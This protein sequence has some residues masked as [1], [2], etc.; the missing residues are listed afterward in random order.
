MDFNPNE[1]AHQLLTFDWYASKTAFTT[2]G[3]PIENLLSLHETAPSASTWKSEDL[4]M[5]SILDILM[6]L[7][8]NFTEY[9]QILTNDNLQQNA[10]GSV[11]VMRRNSPLSLRNVYMHIIIIKMCKFSS[12]TVANVL[13]R[14]I[15]FLYDNIG[16]LDIEL[17]HRIIDWFSHHLSNFLFT[18]TWHEWMYYPAAHS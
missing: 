4:C 18:W 6:R 5:D 13:G 8:G 14:A 17:N 16:T 9:D 12:Q 15:R 3:I 10:D 1:A 7:P 11:T 2:P